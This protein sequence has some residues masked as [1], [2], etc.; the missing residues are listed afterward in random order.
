M[1]D[2]SLPIS[3][4]RDD[5]LLEGFLALFNLYG[6]ER[7]ESTREDSVTQLDHALQCGTLAAH[8]GASETLV[9]AA[10][11]HDVGHLLWAGDEHLRGIDDHH[12]TCALPLLRRVL[13]EAVLEP[14]RMHVQAK[15][16]LCNIE[17]SYHDALSATS[18]HTLQ[19][20]GGV[21]SDAEAEAF[22]LTPYARDAV[23]LRR[24]DDRAK[25]IGA[26]TMPLEDFARL[27]RGLRI[28]H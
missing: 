2:V 20:Q 6:A 9:A 23:L 21:F 3:L 7:Y 4:A 13:P 1:N 11:L 15:R 17:P 16:F 12:E 28:D 22:I 14:I 8:A 26:E 27:L 24:W 5:D 25:T 19:L 10:F 18:K